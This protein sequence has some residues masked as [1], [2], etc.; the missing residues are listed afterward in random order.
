VKVKV[1]YLALIN[2]VTGKYEEE[3]EVEEGETIATLVDRLAGV[4]GQP[5]RNVV[6][7]SGGTRRYFVNFYHNGQLAP[8]EA[9]L[10]P[11]DEVILLLALGGG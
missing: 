10:K 2:S 8:P 5:F 7:A 9:I 6:Y 11:G 1:K 4:Y 3:I